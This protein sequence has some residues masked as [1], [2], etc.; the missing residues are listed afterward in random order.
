LIQDQ[1]VIWLMA[2]EYEKFRWDEVTDKELMLFVKIQSA[3]M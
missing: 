3:I 2:L 1:S